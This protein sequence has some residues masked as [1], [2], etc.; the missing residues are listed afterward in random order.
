MLLSFLS[1][2]LL[3]LCHLLQDDAGVL[4]LCQLCESLLLDRM[5][6]SDEVSGAF[7][8]SILFP[9]VCISSNLFLLP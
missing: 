5:G 2:S 9:N 3:N 1:L 8:Y 4:D 6:H 7:T